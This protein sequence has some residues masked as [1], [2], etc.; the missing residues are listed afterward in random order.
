MLHKAFVFISED[1]EWYLSVIDNYYNEHRWQHGFQYL[2]WPLSQQKRKKNNAHRWRT[3]FL[4]YL[5][6][7]LTKIYCVKYARARISVSQ[8]IK[9][10]PA[11][12]SV[13]GIWWQFH[14]C[15]PQKQ[16]CEILGNMY[17]E[18]NS[19]H[20]KGSNHILYIFPTN[21]DALEATFVWWVRVTF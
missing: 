17:M 16:R 5:H 18:I 14:L 4:V 9:L 12:N 6:S 3:Y 8:L 20:F 10:H 13:T 1:S 11:F 15:F 19:A 21:S 7:M 2:L